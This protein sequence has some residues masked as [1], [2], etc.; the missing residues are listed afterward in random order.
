[1]VSGGVGVLGFRLRGR[2]VKPYCVLF[3][4]FWFL[5]LFASRVGAG[6]VARPVPHEL[7][8]N[9]A[10]LGNT[11]RHANEQ[12][13]ATTAPP[14]GSRNTSRRSVVQI[15]QQGATQQR[16]QPHA[17]CVEQAN[18]KT[19][20]PMMSANH[21]RKV[22]TKPVQWRQSLNS[23]LRAPRGGRSKT[24]GSQA[25]SSAKGAGF[26]TKRGKATAKNAV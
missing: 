18:S 11:T 9:T 13:S 26:S 20:Q 6:C 7:S 8:H 4:V 1:M 24:K 16:R 17:F 2:I 3:C 23:V 21:A 22:T 14:V 15:A 5:T 10:H 25:A 19:N 12:T